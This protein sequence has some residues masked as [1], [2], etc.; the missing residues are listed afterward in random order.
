MA[1][2]QTRMKQKEIGE[3]EA[4]EEITSSDKRM[5]E[6]SDKEKEQQTNNTAGISETDRLQQ[7]S[8]KQ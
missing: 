5:R 6:M 4:E 3:E 7:F 2:H 8:K 1:N